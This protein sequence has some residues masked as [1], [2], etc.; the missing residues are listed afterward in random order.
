MGNETYKRTPA[1]V[2][3]VSVLLLIA[4]SGCILDDKTIIDVYDAVFGLPRD[5]TQEITEIANTLSG[6]Y[7]IGDG[8]KVQLSA[9]VTQSGPGPDLL[10]LTARIRDDKDVELGNQL[11]LLKGKPNK[12]GSNFKKQ[13]FL[14]D[15]IQG[16]CIP[17]GGKLGLEVTPRNGDIQNLAKL[18]SR[19]RVWD[20][21]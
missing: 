8:R 10:E 14:L 19:V 2:W 12:R 15:I 9:K 17:P 13:N 7:C 18:T 4:V 3:I 11:F 20:L 16:N 6:P 5:V 21:D 1:S